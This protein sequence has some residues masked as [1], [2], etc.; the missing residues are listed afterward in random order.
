MLSNKYLPLPQNVC[1][2]KLELLL[3]KQP[4]KH[5]IIEDV[6]SEVVSFLNDNSISPI[7][8]F[9]PEK[10]P[11]R[12]LNINDKVVLFIVED[13][14]KFNTEMLPKKYVENMHFNWIKKGFRVIWIKRFEW[15]DLRKR[16]VLQSLIMHAC[17][18]TKNRTFARKTVAEIIPSKDLREFFENSS[19]YGYRNA[20]FAVCLR[21][22]KT[23]EIL[24]AM[25]FGHPYY[26]KN[27]YGEGAV[28]CI[29]AASKPHTVIVGGMSK[30]M[31]FMIEQFGSS[32]KSILFYVDDSHYFS[33][34][35]KAIGFDYSHFA[36]GASHNVWTKTG[37]MFM[38]TPALHQEI[39]FLNKRGEIVA[40]PDVGNSTFLFKS[41]NA[42]GNANSIES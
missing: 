26:G 16:N 32:F 11:I 29:R 10:P 35:M 21:D 9:I 1:Q 15:E 19:F 34:S 14:T 30:L 40:V 36:G 27:K 6:Y 28:E 31:K 25:S 17:G 5:T 13:Y 18:K 4:N 41:E 7:E 23:N 33:N 38:R 37:S 3:K 8:M 22:K 42:V 24:M 12:I 20:S 2:D 39:A